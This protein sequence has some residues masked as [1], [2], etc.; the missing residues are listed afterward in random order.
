MI[1]VTRLIIFLALYPCLL[2]GFPASPQKPGEV[3]LPEGTRI[4]L[5]LNDHLSTK[6]NSEGN[7]FTATLT[8]P[9][10]QGDR[11]V[12]RKGS[13]VTASVSR[14]VRPGRFRGKAMMTVMFHSIRIPGRRELPLAAS[15]VSIDA[16]GNISVKSEGKIEGDGSKGRDSARA[17]QSG[18]G[19]AGIGA[20][21]GGGKGAAI[22][23]GVGAVIGIATIFSTRGQDLEIPPGSI[24]NIVLDRPLVVPVEPEASFVKQPKDAG[25]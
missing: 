11:E 22:G 7:N 2:G 15:L 18:A 1:K 6:Q 9:V 8:A 14:V 10:N 19:G 16:E 5:Q 20:L 23:T 17:A 25:R 4:A 3:T 21:A 24:L 13:I 12:L